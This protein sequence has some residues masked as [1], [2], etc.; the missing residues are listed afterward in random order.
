MKKILL[1]IVLT[2]LM[3]TSFSQQQPTVVMGANRIGGCDAGLINVDG[4]LV[5]SEYYHSGVQPPV[6][7]A[8]IPWCWWQIP[9]YDNGYGSCV[10]PPPIDYS[11][12]VGGGNGGGNNNN[13]GCGSCSGNVTDGSGR[14]VTSG[15]GGAIG[16]SGPSSQ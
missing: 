1:T 14:N 15:D 3:G 6:A 10:V 12:G 4:I 16:T 13:P 7:V 9:S 2:L 11:M 8:N 5:C